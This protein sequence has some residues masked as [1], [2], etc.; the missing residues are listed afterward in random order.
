MFSS[1]Q[2]IRD[3]LTL[4]GQ[5]LEAE[6]SPG[7]TVLICGGAALNLSD[8]STWTTADV[9][10]LALKWELVMISTLCRTGY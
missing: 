8:L 9:M 3:S 1:V 5:T 6:N 7:I 4:L 2:E 10:S